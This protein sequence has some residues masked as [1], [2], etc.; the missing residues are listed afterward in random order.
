MPREDLT[1]SWRP[2]ALSA[3]GAG[4]PVYLVPSLG[5]TPLSLLRLARAIT[6]RRPTHAFA[7]AGMDDDLPPHRTLEAMATAYVADLLARS[8]PGPYLLG[9]HCVGGSVALEMAL[10]LEARGEPVGRL[11]LL[12]S[13]APPLSDAD[14]ATS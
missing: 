8:A 12:D 1:G 4:G 6:P 11:V 7:Y 3:G 13:M 5:L 2:C 10:Q 9:G 14:G